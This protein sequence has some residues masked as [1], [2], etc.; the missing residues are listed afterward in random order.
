MNVVEVVVKKS[1]VRGGARKMSFVF[2]YSK[3][4]AKDLVAYGERDYNVVNTIFYSRDDYSIDNI[5]D[6]LVCNLFGAS[7]FS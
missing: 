4:F 3:I 6:L 2:C 1:T 7:N 5:G